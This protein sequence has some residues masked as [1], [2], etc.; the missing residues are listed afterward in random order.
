MKVEIPDVAQTLASAAPR[1]RTPEV[2]EFAMSPKP[3]AH[4]R[5]SETQCADTEPRPS[6]SGPERE[7]GSGHFPSPP[8]IAGTT[9]GVLRLRQTFPVGLDALQSGLASG[10][11]KRGSGEHDAAA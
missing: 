4:A 11:H 5:G 10:E 8:Q 7:M 2:T 1:L 3:L 9:S 6:G